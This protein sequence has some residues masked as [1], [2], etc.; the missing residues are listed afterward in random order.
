MTENKKSLTDLTAIAEKK[1]T[2]DLDDFLHK[3]ILDTSGEKLEFPSKR[4]QNLYYHTQGAFHS[5][6]DLV[7]MSRSHFKGRPYDKTALQSF[8]RSA[9]TLENFVYLLQ[10]D[11]GLGHF[12]HCTRW[13]TKPQ[14]SFIQW[15]GNQ[16]VRCF[17]ELGNSALESIYNFCV[18]V[19]IEIGR[20]QPDNS[21]QV[22]PEPD[23]GLFAWLDDVM[24]YLKI[25]IKETNST[26]DRPRRVPWT[27]SLVRQERRKLLM[28]LDGE[29]RWA[30]QSHETLW[31]VAEDCVFAKDGKKWRIAYDGVEAMFDNLRGFTIIHRLLADQ[32]KFTS[33]LDLCGEVQGGSVEPMTDEQYRKSCH[34]RLKEIEDLKDKAKK[35]NDL[36]EIASLENEKIEIIK[37]LNP[38]GGLNGHVQQVSDN[39][40][41]S[42]Q[43]VKNR[44]NNALSAIKSQNPA[45]HDH[46]VATISTGNDCIYRSDFD[47]FWTL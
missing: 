4:L 19:A 38:S 42:R 7:L 8:I 35:N 12:E 46:F 34:D 43:R 21:V 32:G 11:T 10:S 5:A 39:K 17:G 44:I 3:Q 29:F 25:A 47:I 30:I 27:E 28:A 41:W 15:P 36:A 18:G 40:E 16:S 2:D 1:I 37:Y 20:F 6:V 13:P 23:Q 33:C 14:P 9:A 26:H 45:L 22:E 31:K 24:S